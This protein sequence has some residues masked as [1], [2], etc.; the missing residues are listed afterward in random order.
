MKSIHKRL[1]QLDETNASLEKSFNTAN[2]DDPLLLRGSAPDLS[3][4]ACDHKIK[5]ETFERL[6]NNVGDRRDSSSRKVNSS[7]DRLFPSR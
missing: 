3:C 2:K 5:P 1:H 4:F 6:M 7:A